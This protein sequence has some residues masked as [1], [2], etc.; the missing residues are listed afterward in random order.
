MHPTF[1]LETIERSLRQLYEL[2]FGDKYGS[3]WLEELIGAEKVA[4][5]AEK[6]RVEVERRGKRGA[7]VVSS[8]LV[9]YTEFHQLTGI[10]AKRWTE[11]SPALGAKKEFL[12]LLDRFEQLRNTVAHNRPLLSFEKELLSG[13][14]GEIR[15][16]VTIYMSNEP[17]GNEFW[18]RIEIVTDN[19]GHSVD[20]ADTVRTENPSVSTGKTL[21]VG[22]T[23]TFDCRATDPQGRPISWRLY[24]LPGG[25]VA[26][27]TGD[28]VQL[29]WNVQEAS[30]GQQTYAQI[31]MKS[32][33]THHRWSNGSDGLTLFLYQV[34]PP[35]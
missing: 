1:A 13:I 3:N 11:L 23:V 4:Q 7:A 32:D 29:I 27:S 10:A 18:P 34:L 25:E 8:R 5:L 9:D 15:N 35:E 30:V 28:V 31:W 33:R 17:I 16:R 14:A 24:A 26:S 20:G 21:R 19:F 6:R 2:V 22:D 12:P